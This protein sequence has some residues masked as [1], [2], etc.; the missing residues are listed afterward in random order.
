MRY[1]DR[2]VEIEFP[3]DRKSKNKKP[4]DTR[5]VKVVKIPCND[6]QPYSEIAVEV[7]KGRNGDLLLN[8]LKPF[9][10]DGSIELDELRASASK[11]F[12]SED[13]KITRATVDKMTE[14]G[15]VELFP[16]VHPND[17]NKQCKVGLYLDEAGQLKH[18]AP[19]RR[20]TAL[21][22]AC[23]F[24]DVPLVGDMFVGRCGPVNGQLTNIDFTVA[25]MDSGA[26]W[27]RDAQRTNYEHGLRT[28][29]V[30]MESDVAAAAEAS[31]ADPARGLRWSES[32]DLVEVSVVVP[33]EQGQKVSAKDVRVKFGTRSLLVQ[34]KDADG[35]GGMTTLL[36]VPVLA[37]AVRPDE[38]TWSLSGREVEVSMEKTVGGAKARWGRLEVV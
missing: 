36:E 15:S 18:L 35:P 32:D 20:A 25:E 16:L 8:S 17:A 7:E 22:K 34:V 33:G 21:A 28:N 5:V 29:Q 4:V 26:A 12:S 19:N 1:R 14:L 3:A 24:S 6:D 11:Q 38:C 13:V 23:G 27:M 2:G 10:T 30:A 31:G 9:F 37:G